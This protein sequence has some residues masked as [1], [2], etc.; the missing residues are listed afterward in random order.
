MS[1]AAAGCAAPD[2]VS[3]ELDPVVEELMLPGIVVRGGHV[4]RSHAS[5]AYPQRDAGI[6][7]GGER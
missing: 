4:R 5:I 3:I 7:Y 2:I 1:A 6:G